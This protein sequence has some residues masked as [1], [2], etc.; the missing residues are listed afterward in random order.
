MQAKR[1]AAA[2]SEFVDATS[3]Q[4]LNTVSGNSPELGEEEFK[5]RGL[6][7]NRAKI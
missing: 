3:T 6:A 4:P 7:K 1:D 2:A 5:D